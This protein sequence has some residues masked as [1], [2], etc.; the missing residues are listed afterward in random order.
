MS[1][2]LCAI[3]H[4]S[5]GQGAEDISSPIGAYHAETGRGK[6]VEKSKDSCTT[7][8]QDRLYG[9]RASN[10]RLALPEC[11]VLQVCEDAVVA[12]AEATAPAKYSR[13]GKIVVSVSQPL[14]HLYRCSIDFNH[15]PLYHFPSQHPSKKERT[16]HT[17]TANSPTDV[18][19]C[20]VGTPVF[21]DPFISIK[22]QFLLE[23]F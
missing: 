12:V 14:L 15:D 19:V 18:D 21:P 22:E 13:N 3:S 11:W 9:T 16:S 1:C 23:G 20:L 2:I 10:A 17:F 7:E 4:V 6:A 8:H 5:H